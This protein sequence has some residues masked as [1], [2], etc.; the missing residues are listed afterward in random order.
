MIDPFISC[1][2]EHLAEYD[3]TFTLEISWRSGIVWVS[4]TPSG[5]E[6]QCAAYYYNRFSQWVPVR[7]WM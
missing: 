2:I 6:G 3:K 4:I 7:E 5:E 1:V